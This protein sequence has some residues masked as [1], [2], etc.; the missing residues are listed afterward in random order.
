MSVQFASGIFKSE[1]FL[2]INSILT[3]EERKLFSMADPN[4]ATIEEYL[5]RALLGT[6]Q[7]CLKEDLSS[8]PRCR[9]KQKIL[10]VVH[11]LCVYGFYF[12]I[13]Y[14]LTYFTPVK[15]VY[16]Y[17]MYCISLLPIIGPVLGKTS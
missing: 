8:L 4:K 15:I 3:E 11:K 13:F 12:Y 9:R 6:R 5:K 14:L 1:R 17:V 16:D 10:Y 7:Y 2:A